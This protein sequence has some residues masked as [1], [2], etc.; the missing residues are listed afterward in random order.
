MKLAEDSLIEIVD[1][2]REGLV[3]GKD[4]SQMLRDLDLSTTIDGRLGLSKTYNRQ[5]GQLF[6]SPIVKPD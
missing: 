4:I 3:E 5:S 1:I 2:V 6:T